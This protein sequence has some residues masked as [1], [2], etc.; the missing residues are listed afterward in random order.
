M[1][2]GILI[3]CLRS[4][5]CLGLFL[6]LSFS[7]S[8]ARAGEIRVLPDEAGG[9]AGIGD[10][11]VENTLQA[12]PGK[13]RV[14]LN[15]G[16]NR[17]NSHY[18]GE[19]S[20]EEPR[21]RYQLKL[22]GVSQKA[23][24]DFPVQMLAFG[25]FNVALDAE[26]QVTVRLD[27]QSNMGA[28]KW[29][30]FSTQFK[31]LIDG[32][33]SG[34]NF[35][36]NVFASKVTSYGIQRMPKSAN[37]CKGLSLPSGYTFDQ[38]GI[39][40]FTRDNRVVV[41]KGFYRQQSS[42]SDLKVYF[43]PRKVIPQGTN[44]E[45]SK[46]SANNQYGNYS[47][48]TYTIVEPTT[49]LVGVVDKKGWESASVGPKD[50]DPS[51]KTVK[52]LSYGVSLIDFETPAD[53]SN[54][55][56]ANGT[57]AATDKNSLIEAQEIQQLYESVTPPLT[58]PLAA[59]F[60]SR[61]NADISVLNVDAY[62][63]GGGHFKGLCGGS[64]SPL[65]VFFDDRRPDFRNATGFPLQKA[66][67]RTR[68]P[69]AHSPGYF[70]ALDE[71]LNGKITM[72]QELFGES[73]KYDN[74]FEALKRFDLNKDGVIN[75]KDPVFARLVLWNDENGDGI[76]QPNE[77]FKLSD[78]GIVS[79]HL[80]YKPIYTR[81]GAFAEARQQAVFHYRDRGLASGKTKSSYIEDV[82]FAPERSALR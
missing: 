76:S 73:S 4:F 64:A 49:E 32:V 31:G 17:P 18:T 44:P 74:G 22:K 50:G 1:K 26:R 45:N 46:S 11:I 25:N 10:I 55:V 27:A 56:A 58:H 28:S 2:R 54:L 66:G 19:V 6:S 82:W 63:P 13:L 72:Q 37:S 65:M 38:C 43:V 3:Q 62:V 70:L 51:A 16:C 41:L 20:L 42:G 67:I 33:Y 29:G 75:S 61:F 47:N 48:T 34:L 68:W 81:F 77:L 69:A 23:T 35:S 36:G 78:M 60:T 24:I 5:L 21:L 57:F 53:F 40:T 39:A 59:E 30:V 7:F 52:N 79:I 12:S 15:L 80:K 9:S 71:D 14:L 8:L